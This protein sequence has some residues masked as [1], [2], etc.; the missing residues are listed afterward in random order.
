MSF[1]GRQEVVDIRVQESVIICRL[2][3]KQQKHWW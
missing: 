3:L 2:V 1:R